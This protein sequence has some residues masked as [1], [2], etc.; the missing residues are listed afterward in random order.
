MDISNN[1]DQIRKHFNKSFRTN[2]HMAVASVNNE[3]L[4][5]VTPIGS[6]FLNRDQ[7]GFYFEKYPDTLPKNAGYNKNIC[8][9]GV[10]SNM[11]FWLRSLFKGRFKTYPAV[12]LYGK[13][14][15]RRPATN[16]EISRLNRRMKATRGLKGNRYLWGEMKFVRE[17]EFTNARITQ[18]GKMT[19]NL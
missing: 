6:L 12:K 8:I 3:N 18:M 16:K 15:E 17:I 4:P 9:L 1:W 19:E 13:L 5:D 10:N 7:T 2:F 11:W 14:G